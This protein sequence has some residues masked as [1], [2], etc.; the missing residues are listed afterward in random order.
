MAYNFP[1]NPNLNDTYTSNGRTFRWNGVLWQA[2]VVP[3]ANSAP[4]FISASPPPNPVAGALWYSTTQNVLKIWVIGS[5][6]GSWVDL[7]QQDGSVSAPVYISASPPTD[8]L[9]GSLWYNTTTSILNLWE[10]TLGGGEWVPLNLSP[11]C[12]V[13]YTRTY[14]GSSP[15][16]NPEPGNLWW[17]SGTSNLNIWY[18]DM[19]G[20]Q[21]VSVVPYPVNEITQQ[22]GI[23]IGPIYGNYEIP[24]DPLAFVTTEWVENYVE[25][26]SPI[27]DLTDA[28]DVDETGLTNNS[29]F[30]YRNVDA[31]WTVNVT[32]LDLVNGGTF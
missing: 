22:G 21:W 19:G 24:D 23:F 7:Y 27:F 18:E 16:A 15:P 9:F 6:G 12:P 29:V 30:V 11:D 5:G 26:Y 28:A 4:V 20:G 3:T 31:K 32:T 8:P 25:S 10:N 2:V 14:I 17:D 1:P 13:D